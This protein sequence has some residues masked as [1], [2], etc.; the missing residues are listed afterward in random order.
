MESLSGKITGQDLLAEEFVQ[1]MSEIQNVI[2][3]LGQALTSS[4]LN[5]LGKA[6]AGYAANGAFYTDSGVADAYVLTTIGLKQ[7]ATEYTDGFLASFIASNQSTGAVTVD[8][9]GV[10]AKDIRLNGGGRYNE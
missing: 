8:V 1:P 6:I 10:G 2:E 4:D 5:Q 7:S 9:A 3:Q